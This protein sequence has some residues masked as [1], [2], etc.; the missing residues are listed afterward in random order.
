MPL[1]HQSTKRARKVQSQAS[2]LEE[3][4]HGR[5]VLRA[6]SEP[7]RTRCTGSSAKIC[8]TSPVLRKQRCARACEHARCDATLPKSPYDQTLLNCA[9]ARERGAN[10][11]GR[12]ICA[13]DSNLFKPY[14]NQSGAGRDAPLAGEIRRVGGRQLGA[15]AV[16]ED[17]DARVKTRQLHAARA[18][19]LVGQS[20][21]RAHTTC[22]HQRAGMLH[23][24]A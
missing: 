22:A 7:S 1:A 18:R 2:F 9:E 19:R 14:T 8:S 5:T 10:Q 4:A 20:A 16:G 23:A 21:L 24:R 3:S 11:I 17:A 12:E 6:L 15:G 13:P